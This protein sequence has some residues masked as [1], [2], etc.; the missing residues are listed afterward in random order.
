LIDVFNF[1]IFFFRLF[2]SLFYSSISNS[3]EKLVLAVAGLE[4][5]LENL[6]ENKLA[7][8]FEMEE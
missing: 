8:E 5:D 4:K 1:F 2:I 6:Q 3:C 7:Q